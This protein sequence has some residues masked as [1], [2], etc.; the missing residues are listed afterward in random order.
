MKHL[1]SFLL[2][3][4]LLLVSTCWGQL[5]PPSSG[6]LN[7]DPVVLTCAPQPKVSV[8]VTPSLR[9]QQLQGPCYI[10]ATIA[11]LESRALQACV[12]IGSGYDEWSLY[13]TCLLGGRNGTGHI[14]IP[15]VVDVA[16]K[17][18]VI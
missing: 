15:Q 18:G 9:D 17:E 3:F 7:P 12:N 4:C 11:A 1:S 6:V 8:P 14:M 16:L 10:F 2:G 13:N 5:I